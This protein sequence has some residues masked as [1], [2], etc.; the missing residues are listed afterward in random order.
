MTAAMPD[1][2]KQ[3]MLGSVPLG[4]PAQPAEIA[5]AVLFLASSSAAYITGHVLMVDGG[6][7]M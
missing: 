4:R 5:S 1:A 2:A 7:A 6:M 3:A